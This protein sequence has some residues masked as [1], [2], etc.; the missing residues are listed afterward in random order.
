[1]TAVILAC[2]WRHLNL[3]NQPEPA[4]PAEPAAFRTLNQTVNLEL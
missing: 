2:G 3:L 1:M 4:E